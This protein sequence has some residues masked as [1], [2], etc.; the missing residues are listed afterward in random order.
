MSA[1]RWDGIIQQLESR[2]IKFDAG[3]SGVEI[4][5]AERCFAFRFPSDLREFLQTALPSG[6]PFPNWRSGD[7]AV[8]RDWFD[9]PRQG[10]LFDV[11]RNGFWLEEWGP[12]PASMQE[13]LRA[14]NDLV[15]AAPKLIPIY[16]HRMMPEEP[17]SAG[18]PVFSVHQTDIIYYGFDLADYLRHEF[19]LDGREPWPA[20]MRPIRFWDIDRF[21]GVRW[22]QGPCVFDNSRGLLP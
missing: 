1:V 10:I 6:K 4:T 11:E 21:Q 17:L 9:L 13:A 14:A 22:S 20:E 7:E 16:I 2:G 19:A 5:A 18:N 12:I 15:Q 8:L 3:L